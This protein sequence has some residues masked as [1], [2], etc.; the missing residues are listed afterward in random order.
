MSNGKAA[1][2]DHIQEVWFK[3]ATSLHPKLKQHLQEC[4][5]TGQVPTWMT[6]GRA[7]LIMKDKSKGT[8]VGNYRPIACLPLM[9]KL[10]TAIFSEAMYGYLSCQM[11]RKM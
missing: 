11:N 6:E 10:F 4:V 8:V 5:N 9:W 2:S 3:E 7:V 1:G